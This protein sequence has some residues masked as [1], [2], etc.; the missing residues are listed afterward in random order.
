V[1]GS[2]RIKLLL[3]AVVPTMLAVLVVGAVLTECQTERLKA[4][5]LEK[6]TRY[7]ELASVQLRSAIAFDDRETARETVNGIVR[8]EDVV[9][10]RLYNE[11]GEELHAYGPPPGTIVADLPPVRVRDTFVIAK[12]I[13]ALEGPRG[14]IEIAV[15]THT[16]GLERARIIRITMVVAIIAALFAFAIAFP[17][18]RRMT[19]R[20]QSVSRYA[21]GIAKGS[22][23][24]EPLDERGRDEVSQTAAAV[25]TMVAQL[26][27]LMAQ[28]AERAAD[29]QR[30]VLDHVNQGMFAVTYDGVLVGERSSAT[31]SML[32]AIEAND[33]L[34]TIAQRHDERTAS[35]FSLGFAQLASDLLP[36]E[37]ALFQLPSEIVARGR[38]L[39][40]KYT[41]FWDPADM[42]HR[43]LVT[44]TDITEEREHALA[45]EIEEE[46]AAF[47]KQLVSDRH[48]LRRFVDDARTQ[49]E[50]VATARSSDVVF[51]A[52]HTL[53][54]NAGLMGLAGWVTRC[55][56]AENTLIEAGDLTADQRQQIVWA[57]SATEDRV[58]P[59]IDTGTIDMSIADHDALVRIARRE[60]S[61]A[62][63]RALLRDIMMESTAMPLRML[64]DH[65]RELTARHG[66]PLGQLVVEDH[67]VRLS[68]DRWGPLWSVLT[69]VVRNVVVHGMHEDKPTNVTLRTTRHGEGITIEITDDGKGIAWETLRDR[70]RAA[71]LPSD[72][73]ADLVA[74]L[75]ASRITTRDVVD[76]TAGRGVGL[77]AVA[78]TCAE[79]GVVVDLP[80]QSRG[81][82]FHFHLPTS[83]RSSLVTIERGDSCVATS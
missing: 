2:I 67:G 64:A 37:V 52:L 36:L 27:Q 31:E 14:L 40:F 42:N 15:S 38:T 70:A 7:G 5:L 29:Q 65:T 12:S 32:G 35:A 59:L 28:Q 30:L 23:A 4:S 20:I 82:A 71:G 39:A 9:S 25:N 6:A 47:F 10:V 72:S 19:N 45:R 74:A 69:H 49:I 13:R 11:T 83:S 16:L 55:H 60:T 50:L 26:Q 63:L 48:G 79:L 44:I 57:W 53:K 61:W 66:R 56:E 17:I 58:L 62:D 46:S 73:R 21:A 43:L 54:G 8:D 68:P 22:L 3:L 34:A 18:A 24:I 51:A 75:F 41:Q 77:A 33:S 1:L 76:E 78:A 80:E 81:T